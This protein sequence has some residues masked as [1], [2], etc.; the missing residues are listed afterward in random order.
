VLLSECAAGNEVKERKVLQGGHA[1]TLQRTLGKRDCSQNDR[2]D[3]N[4]V[5]QVHSCCSVALSACIRSEGQSKVKAD[6]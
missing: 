6:G 3:G 4:E 5:L 1:A 2:M